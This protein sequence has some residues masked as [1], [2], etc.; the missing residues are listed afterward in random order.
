MVD[1]GYLGN[2]RLKRSGVEISYTQEQLIE[3]AKCADDP[4]YFIKNYVKIVNVDHGLVPFNMW[5]FQS[6]MVNT[7]HNNRFSIAKM[8]RQV[9]K[10]TTAAGYMLWC[11]LFQENYSIAILANKGA[12]AQD[13]L[14]R[15]QYAF[16]YLPL[17][18]QQGIIVWNKRNI[19]LENGSK[20]AAYATSAAGVRGGSYNLIFLDEFAFVPQNMANDFFTSTYPV[21]SSGTTTKVIIVS[22]PYGLNH[23]YKMWVDAEE[24]RSDYKT[25]EVHWSMVPGRDAAWREQT[26]RNTSEEQFRQEFECEFIGSSATLIP[27]VKLRALAFKSPIKSIE[28]MD[29]YREPEENHTYIITVDCAEGVGQDYSAFSVF[30]VTELPYRQIAKFKNNTISPMLY[31]SIVYNAARKFNNAFVLVE[32]N[33]IGQQ[34]VDILHYDL[35]Y[36]NIFRL[37]HHSIKGQHISAGFKKSVSFG[38]KTT[39]SVKKIGCANLKTLVE[40]DKLIIEDFDTISELNTFVRVKDSY[41]AEEGNN[42]DVVMT[43]VFFSWLTAQSYFKEITDSDVRKKLVEERNIHMEEDMSPVGILDDEV[44]RQDTFVEDGDLW[45]LAKQ[46]GYTPSNL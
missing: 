35:E 19:E 9:G 22:T 17:W 45:T 34:V 41:E 21:I 20:I 43:L 15:I 2:S 46:R 40:T 38:L 18:L 10:T 25:I 16:E 1:E 11:V 12:L 26:I 3:V 23:F 29:L 6:D 24:G 37:E 14:S 39:K 27:A 13:I 36:E 28:D 30:D 4:E 32:T 42:D 8:P 31:P 7:F 44:Y 33:N 5:D